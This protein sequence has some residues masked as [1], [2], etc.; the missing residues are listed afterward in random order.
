MLFW[1][2]LLL[3]KI[4]T[5][6]HTFPRDHCGDSVKHGRIGGVPRYL[7]TLSSSGAGF[8]WSIS[9]YD[10]IYVHRSVLPGRRGRGWDGDPGRHLCSRPWG[11]GPGQANVSFS[12]PPWAAT[13]RAPLWPG[14]LFPSFSGLLHCRAGLPRSEPPG[15]VSKPW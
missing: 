12:S 13:L 11:W 2:S 7:G 15:L 3:R 1:N 9:G 10:P 4:L 5:W 8:S 14:L 6:S